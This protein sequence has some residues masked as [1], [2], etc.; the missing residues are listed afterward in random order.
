M[1]ASLFQKAGMG[2]FI[3]SSALLIVLLFLNKYRLTDAALE[4]AVTDPSERKMLGTAL[5]PMK[6]IAYQSGYTFNENI[7]EYLERENQHIS[8]KFEITDM[9]IGNVISQFPGQDIQY[10]N[11]KITNAFD[12]TETGRFKARKLKDY[13]SWMNERQYESEQGLRE[14]LENTRQNINTS[15]IN[16]QGFS[17]YKI[18]ALKLALTRHSSFGPVSENTTLWLVLTIGLGI[19]GALIFILPKLKLLPGIKNDHVFHSANTGRGWIGYITG[20]L[21]IGFYVI[22]YWYPEYMTS[23]MLLVDPISK[24]LNGHEASQW[25]FYGFL[26]TLAIGVM[27]VR[28]IIKYR[29]SKYHIIRTLSVIFFQVA[30]AFLIPE[31]LIR[32]NQPSMDLK[33]IWPLNYTFF[34]DYNLSTLTSSGTIGIAMLVWGIIL[35]II[36]VPVITYFYGKRWYCSWVCGCGGLAETLGDPYRQL[37]DKSLKAWQIER[38]MVHGI[39]VFSVIMTIGV[40]YTYFTGSSML[41]GINT[42]DIRSV[43]GF[44]IGAAFA[45]VVGVGFY[46]FMGNRVWCR[47]GCPLAAYL[48]IV[49]R[50][51]SRFRI[52]T[53]GGQCISCGNC[54]TYCEMGIDVRWYAQRGQNIIRASCVGCG[55]C[56]SVCPRGVLKLENK[57]PKGRFGEPILIGNDSATIRS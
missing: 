29:H 9:D 49:Q 10:S 54:S 5:S 47:F 35:I 39:L 42:Y 26:Y 36:G 13:T 16:D 23:W 31:I 6:G 27:G 51:K 33:N 57:D 28:M 21:L 7:E 30:F 1:K 50:F 56:S 19:L 15:I 14:Q 12:T 22:L 17:D 45:G 55:V 18:K 20:T 52:T 11:E 3:I 38:W 48:G 41:L 24:V 46:P 32:L 37:S 8:S 34:F 2:I 44:L 40:L 53:N 4:R 43:Y 25:F